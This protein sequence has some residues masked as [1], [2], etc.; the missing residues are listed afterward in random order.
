MKKYKKIV[1]TGGN[2]RFGSCL[3]KNS[4]NHNMLF[5]SKIDL[6]ICNIKSITK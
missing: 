5:P 4:G 3:K 6:N 1:V 2:G